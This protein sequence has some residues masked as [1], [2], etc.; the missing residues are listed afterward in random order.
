MKAEKKVVTFDA[1]EE[2]AILEGLNKIR[3]EQLEKGGAAD[4]IST[5]ILKII[6]TPTR[7]ARGRNEAR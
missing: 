6:R 1:Y 2:G 7:K 4:F 5:L 3:T